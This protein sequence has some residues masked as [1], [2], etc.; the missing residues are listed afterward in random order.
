MIKKKSKNLSKKRYN[1]PS[2]TQAFI[3]N[4]T[5]GKNRYKVRRDKKMKRRGRNTGCGMSG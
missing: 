1:D 2:E 3:A 4:A 5:S